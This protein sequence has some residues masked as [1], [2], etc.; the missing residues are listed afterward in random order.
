MK[1]LAGVKECNSVLAE[2]L[3]SAG[4]EL[5]EVDKTRS[6]V[7]YTYVGKAGDWTL[8]RAWYYWVASTEGQGLPLAIAE[9]MHNKPYP[10]ALCEGRKI[11]YGDQIRVAGHCG[12]PPPN[13]WAFPDF[14]ELLPQLDEKNITDR[15]Y[16][17]LAK[18]LDEGVLTGE[19]FVKNYHIDSQ[20]GLNEFVRV[21]KSLKS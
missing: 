13:E 15:T 8:T 20:E 4:A 3:L 19:R 5:V 7:P 17:N 6:E 12:C 14:K 10:E 11:V 18:L 1:N 2:E 21:V 9:V 16:G